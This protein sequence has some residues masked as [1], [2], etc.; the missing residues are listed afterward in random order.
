MVHLPIQQTKPAVNDTSLIGSTLG[1]Y[2]LLELI[3]DGGMGQVFRAA[4]LPTGATVALKL[5]HPELSGVD[6][7]VRRFE[8]EARLTTQL[9]HPNIVKVVEFG[10][11]NGRLFLAM[12]LLSGT[13]LGQLIKRHG[14]AGSRFTVKRTLS[15]VGPVLS[16][17]EY[18]HARGVVHR[19]LK[20]ENIMVIPPRG[21]FSPERI[22]LLDFGIAKLG[23]DPGAKGRKLTQVGLVLGTPDYMSPEQAAGQQ[24]DVRSDVYSC[25]VILYEMLT[26][27]RPFEAD[28]NLEVLAMHLNAAPP[29]LRAVAGAAR[30]PV[31]VE[32]VVLRT[33]A[34]RPEERFQSARE[35]REA[36]ERAVHVRDS[37][38]SV[39]GTEK[40]IFA[41]SRESPRP[42]RW[43][44]LAII[45]AAMAMLAGDHVQI[46]A[47]KSTRRTTSSD[48]SDSVRRPRVPAGADEPSPTRERSRRASLA[49][50]RPPSERAKQNARQSRAASKKKAQ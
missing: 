15:I 30:I 6:E 21:L 3:G 9:A 20:P 41:G 28:S 47:P 11:C 5:L 50:V 46:G 32:R 2:R 7:V 29:P 26:G 43:S 19:D 14:T 34:K 22:K 10:K 4:R 44:R 42:S 33:L 37:Q 31:A 27:R 45:A 40:T 35:V 39:T 17:L 18:A 38:A 13:S 25:G 49:A 1:D 8:L 24:A 23:D 12:E 16:A 48:A 36:L